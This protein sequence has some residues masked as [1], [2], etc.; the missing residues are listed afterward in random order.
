MASVAV[1]A[2]ITSTVIFAA[3]ALPMLR[4]ARATRDLDSYS[5]GNIG[6]AN[7]GNAVHSVYVLHLPPG[8]IWVLHGFYVVSSALML[9]WYVRY[10]VRGRGRHD[11]H[12]GA[13][14]AGTREGT[15]ALTRRV[16]SAPFVA[17]AVVARRAGEELLRAIRV[18]LGQLGGEPRRR[19]PADGRDRPPTPRHQDRARLGDL[20]REGVG[21]QGVVTGGS[22]AHPGQ[23]R[24]TPVAASG[25]SNHVTR[26]Y[27]HSRAAGTAHQRR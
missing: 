17:A 1:L 8:P 23:R 21:G 14:R 10:A 19:P 5:P 20:P 3:A 26:S 25:G 12:R 16:G 2:G 6:L 15:G 18:G 9:V 13:D 7:V 22:R 11:R 27:P 24:G 4:K